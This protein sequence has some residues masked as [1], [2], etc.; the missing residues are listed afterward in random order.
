MSKSKIP[1]KNGC[2][3]CGTCCVVY[4]IDDDKLQKKSY[5]PCKHLRYEGNKAKCSIHA[6]R[7]KSEPQTCRD[8]EPQKREKTL[9]FDNRFSF[10]KQREFMEHWAWCARQGYLDHL[11][12]MI[13]VK[14]QDYS[15]VIV[16]KVYR[17]FIYP[18]LKQIEGTLANEDGWFQLWPGVSEYITKAPKDTWQS[19]IGLTKNKFDKNELLMLIEL[20]LLLHTG[21]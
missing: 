3:M 12:I 19:W 1:C 15:E 20:K 21:L 16:K 9:W 4:T 5:K 10:Y 11:P 18:Y 7:G 6:T 2:I 8:Y 13:A 17:Y 14:K